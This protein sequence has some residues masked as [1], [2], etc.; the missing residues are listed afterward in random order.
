MSIPKKVYRTI[1]KVVFASGSILCFNYLYSKYAVR[2]HIL[3]TSPDNFYDWKGIKINYDKTGSGSPVILL[4][5]IHPA[6]SSFEWHRIVDL[7]SESHTVYTVD[8][9]GCGRSD[10]PEILYVNFYYV[11]FIC[12][13][14]MHMNI[15]NPVIVASNLTTAAAIMA[16]AYKKGLIR[17]CIL[18][19]PPSISSLSQKPNPISKIR[20]KVLTAPLIGE[21]IYNILSSRMQIDMYFAE[22]YFYNPFHGT[23][24]LVD[25]YFESSHLGNGKGYYLAASIMSGYLNVN[26]TRAL[27]QANIPFKIIEGKSTEDAEKTVFEWTHIRPNI[28]TVYIEHTKTLPML[29]EPE[30]TAEEILRFI[31][32]C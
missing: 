27:R 22:T 16:T 23:D 17:K 6:A 10:R 28:E 24:Q 5:S 7:L 20:Y 8:L 29:E 2:N 26:V 25:T 12:D 19:N 32:A 31:D 3:N 18:I 1:K 21:L 4:H 15:R 9:P 14:I 11:Q 30:K 13:F